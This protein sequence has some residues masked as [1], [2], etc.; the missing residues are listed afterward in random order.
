MTLLQ[1][2]M[3]SLLKLTYY[4]RHQMLSKQLAWFFT[5]SGNVIAANIMIIDGP[6]H[7][8]PGKRV[9]H[10]FCIFLPMCST[11]LYGGPFGNA[12]CD[13]NARLSSLIAIHSQCSCF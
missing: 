12:Y 11:M 6:N 2:M 10:L 7:T 5:C 8:W 1:W 3:N 4:F 13:W 9:G